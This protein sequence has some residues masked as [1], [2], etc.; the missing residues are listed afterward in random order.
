MIDQHKTLAEKFLKKWFWLYLFSFIIAPIWY[1]IKIIISWEISVSELGILYWIISLL[2]LLSSF[3]D[4]WMTESLKHFLP[5][6]I[7]EK[8]YDKVKSLLVYAFLS[9]IITWILITSFFF[10]WADYIALNYFKSEE[11]IWAL[12]IFAF[13]FLWINIFQIVQSFFMSVQNTFFSKLI[14]F[15]RIWFTLISTLS[16]FFLDLSNIVNFS[17]SWIIW[18]YLWILFAT[19]FFY[20]NYYKKYL[21]DTKIIWSKKLFKKIFS[22]AI[23]V[24]IWAQASSILGQIDMQ[25]IIYLLWTTDAWYYTNYL[26]IVSIPFMLIWPIFWLLFPIFSEMHAKK[27]HEK[28][29]LVKQVFVN[30]F[31]AIAIAFNILFFVFWPIIAYILFWEKYTFSGEILRYSILFLVFNFLL[32]INFNILAWVWRVI[33]RV[34]IISIA[35]VFNFTLNLILINWID[36]IWFEGIWVVWAALATWIGWILIYVMSEIFLGKKYFVKI[37]FWF[38]AKN[39]F[40]M[41]I[42]WLI[43]YRFI[44]PIFEWYWRWTSFWLMFLIWII[45]FIIFFLIN[46]KEFKWFFSQIK[47]FRK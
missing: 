2:T 31:S 22:Y 7:T 34:K 33:E 27:D 1:I 12:K 42:L 26:S 14:E 15:L 37:D 19:I 21:S 46:F 25:M 6:Y 4:F 39:I 16:I 23:L 36:Y 45:W 8:K 32:Q 20:K 47:N 18:L 29:K 17:Y 35:L 40:S 24:F 3:N 9:Q 5:K 30:N 43:F 13:F 11:A 44:T 41:W 38:L 10:F 28:I